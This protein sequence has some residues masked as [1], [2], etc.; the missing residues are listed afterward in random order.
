M[1]YNA[2][3]RYQCFPSVVCVGEERE[4]RIFPRDVSRRFLPDREYRMQVLGLLEDQ[5]DY[6]DV[7]PMDHP[8]TVK[9][10]C[11]C[12]T[13]R[14]DREQEYAVH[15]TENGGKPVKVFLYA[16]KEDLY[17]LRPL[18]GDLHTHTYYSDGQ[19]G[20]PQT[21][22][23]YREEGFDFFALT[24]HN[25]LYPSQLISELFRDIPL[26]IHMMTGEEVHTPG[27]MLH[28]VHVGGKESVCDRYVNHREEFDAEIAALEA[29]L[30]HVDE[31]YRHRFAMAK[32]ACENIRKAGGLA[33][34]AHPCWMPRRYVV[35]DDYLNL[36]MD[37][38]IFDALE[39]Q[40]GIH[41]RY[42]NMQIALWQ[43]QA[44][45]GNYLPPVGSSDSH[46]HDRTVDAF[47]RRFTV[48]FA[49][50]NDTESIL[51]AIRK[52]YTLAAEISRENEDEVRFYGSLRL[53]RFAHFL[54]QHYFNE[55]YRLC[56]GEGILMRRYSEGD[57]SVVPVLSALAG[58][59]EQYYNK[60]YG[61]TAPAA[62]T[63]K[64]AS[65]LDRCL[66]LQ[67]TLGPATKGSYVTLYGGNERRE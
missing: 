33:I 6:H 22:A 50:K 21:P 26:G 28:I 8:C 34:F 54:Y 18:K 12:F 29:T 53:V 45:K 7:L 38:K 2:H 48:V 64:T 25:R 55:T 56:M 67:R 13:Y 59:V 11:L 49:E 35:S 36:L 47:A 4:I 39:I 14:F 62:L 63:E 17:A 9:D 27:S 30:S 1:M 42:N 5:L 66:E 19:D 24:D 37:A 43:E 41:C 57:E 31:Q 15:F 10:G 44:M 61:K 3:P 51:S 16:V 58:T 20:I 52:G 32:W 60:F 40:N 23:D 65:F 46:K